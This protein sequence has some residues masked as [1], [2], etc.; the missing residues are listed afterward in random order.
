MDRFLSTVTVALSSGLLCIAVLGVF[1][2]PS[3]SQS[4]SGGFA[5]GQAKPD[6]V[7]IN[8]DRAM[9]YL[10]DICAIGPRMSGTAGMKKQQDVIRDHFTK[11]GAT[12]KKQSFS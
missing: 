11:L 6:P 10:K 5:A 1:L 7:K 2:T 3:S 9:G 4:K 12:V 8:G